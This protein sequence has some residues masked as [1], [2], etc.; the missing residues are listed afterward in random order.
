[1]I[2]LI[3]RHLLSAFCVLCALLLSVAALMSVHL[4]EATE[5]A[6]GQ[7]SATNGFVGLVPLKGPDLPFQFLSKVPPFLYVVRLP[8]NVPSNLAITSFPSVGTWSPPYKEWIPGSNTVRRIVFLRVP[9]GEAIFLTNT[10]GAAVV[11]LESASKEL[12]RDS[13]WSASAWASSSSS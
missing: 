10:S 13:A 2:A 5:T 1:M 8:G 4:E 9:P 11:P 6:P 3:R 12:P 7:V